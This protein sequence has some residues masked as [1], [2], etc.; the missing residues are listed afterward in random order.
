MT[1]FAFWGYQLKTWHSECG[2][3]IQQVPTEEAFLI[4][5]EAVWLWGAVQIQPH[6]F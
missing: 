5:A 4:T 1:E 2:S 3:L 6:F